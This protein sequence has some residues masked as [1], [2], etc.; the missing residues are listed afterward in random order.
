VILGN[1][2]ELCALAWSPDGKTL[3]AADAEQVCLWS[4]DGQQSGVIRQSDVRAIAWA[5]TG[6]CLAIASGDSPVL[7]HMAGSG[8]RTQ[9]S[10]EEPV[11]SMA[12]APDGA[13]LAYG[14]AD[15]P[16]RIAD[17][18][19]RKQLSISGTHGEQWIYG[20][21]WSP[22]GTALAVGTQDDAHAVRVWDITHPARRRSSPRPKVR[23]L[24]GPGEPADY[25]LSTSWSPDG[26]LLAVGFQDGA[27]R[28]FNAMRGTMLVD[29]QSHSDEVHSVAF[30]HDGMYLATMDESGRT[31]LWRTGD[32]VS[33]Q[34]DGP[35]LG[36]R[37]SELLAF[38]PG[39]RTLAMPDA[40]G[41]GVRLLDIDSEWTD[42]L[43][44]PSDDVRYN[45]A[46]LV[47]VGESGVG[48]T[49]LGW[50]LAYGEF[51]EH[52]STH[53][54]QFWLL[55]EL[56]QIRDDGTL[57]ETVLWDL[58]GQPDYRIVHTLYLDDVDVAL[59]VVDPTR[60]H[61]LNTSVDYWL[62]QLRVDGTRAI[63]ALLIGA[64][65]DRG[66]PALTP[67]ALEGICESRGIAGYLA[68]SAKDGAGIPALIG[69]IR[70]LVD[71]D[72]RPVTVSSRAFKR[73]KDL[74]LEVKASGRSALVAL[75]QVPALLMD[76]G[77]D[78]EP[79]GAPVSPDEVVRAVRHLETHGFVKVVSDSQAIR[80]V[81]L[82]PELLSN[83]AASFVLEAR[84]DPRG[85]GV[86]D[87]DF[88]ADRRYSFPELDSV[89]PD[90]GALLTDATIATFI[91]HHVCF[92]QILHGRRL[93]VF[94]SLI[95]EDPPPE[96]EQNRIEDVSY[97]VT[98]P[99][100]N[101]Y[102]SLTVQLCYTDLFQESRH[103]QARSAFDIG[104]GQRCY[105]QVVGATAGLVQ[106][107]I[108]YSAQTTAQQRALF[109]ALVD[110]FLAGAPGVTVAKIA[111]V[112]CGMCNEHLPQQIVRNRLQKG[113]RHSF[114]GNCGTRLELRPPDRIGEP[115]ATVAAGAASPRRRSD[116][117]T[118]YESV[119]ARIKTAARLAAG[120]AP[121]PSCF[122]S[123]AWAGPEEDQWVVRLARDVHNS[124]IKVYLDRWHC[125]PGEDISR[126]TDLIAEAKFAIVIGTPLL[127]SKYEDQG[128]DP[129]LKSELELISYRL[130]QSARYGRTV[131]PVLR[132]GS[133]EESFPVQIARL[134]R[135]DFR[136]DAGYFSRV[137]ELVW[138]LHGLSLDHPLLD[139][140]R[141]AVG[142]PG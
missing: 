86:L 125:P 76:T 106:F 124:G 22:D 84:R 102:A 7:L 94:P 8:Q 92:R 20:L 77:S 139:E 2:R 120:D 19:G 17:R 117:R 35:A 88:L 12:W 79:D 6:D 98:G 66:S 105:L 127:K 135:H 68:T 97:E 108:S 69:R 53:G 82:T 126:F 27:V 65:V 101:L 46:K 5:P 73:A 45:T 137:L 136:E 91:R 50:R 49:G 112:V 44:Q 142:A 141:A 138:Q 132:A 37:A 110:S 87:E 42:A 57:C 58:A 52:S 26:S 140:L 60:R 16:V 18:S 39:R 56:T 89:T 59:L 10:D 30:S 15:H 116:R 28:I 99:T 130:R 118:A 34:I 119:V 70:Q 32:W 81:L 4:P 14:G 63:P 24:W 104:F 111:A 72:D 121:P 83:L 21:S 55:P 13:S 75:D 41:A 29:L 131:I 100:E 38:H 96:L 9:L 80:Y 123:Y 43:Q 64:R 93:L 134:A 61:D 113:E 48:K 85:L 62:E 71:W 51:R 54:Q 33:L 36:S 115:A 78:A 23:W 40:S 128:G 90:E 3:A 129:V 95:N 122:I 31:I 1:Q 107:G 47:L 114:C 74:V 109:Q 133:G 103:W 67:A 11:L 25:A